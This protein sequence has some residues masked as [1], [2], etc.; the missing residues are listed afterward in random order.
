M[1]PA[2]PVAYLTFLCHTTTNHK[3]LFHLSFFKKNNLF[4]RF[5]DKRPIANDMLNAHSEIALLFRPLMGEKSQRSLCPCCASQLSFEKHF[6]SCI[7]IS[8]HC[9]V[10]LFGLFPCIGWETN[11]MNGLGKFHGTWEMSGSPPTHRIS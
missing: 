10:L 2:T 6:S 8:R 11:E 7:C 4:A 3:P 9:I 1:V 5:S